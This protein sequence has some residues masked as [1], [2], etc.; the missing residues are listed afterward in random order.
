MT[1][2]EQ[3]EFLNKELLK[4]KDLPVTKNEE[5]IEYKKNDTVIF[6]GSLGR[7]VKKYGMYKAFS[8]EGFKLEEEENN[9]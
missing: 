9:K 6:T 8:G 7:H 5:P 3:A 1:P 2:Q 4:Y